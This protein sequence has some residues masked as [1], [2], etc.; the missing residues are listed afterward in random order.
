MSTTQH[1]SRDVPKSEILEKFEEPKRNTSQATGDKRRHTDAD[2]I[3]NYHGIPQFNRSNYTYANVFPNMM[4]HAYE[5]GPNMNGGG[6]DCYIRGNPGSGKSTFLNWLAARL[7]EINDEQVVWRGSSSRSEW[8]P[9]AP[10]TRLCVPEGADIKARLE[11]RDPRESS[12]D[13][14]RDDLEE[15]AREVVTYRTPTDLNK[16]VLDNGAFHVVYPD[17]RMRGCNEALEESA[18]RTIET[19]PNRDTAFS[20]DDPA[21]HWWFAWALARVERGPY[22]FCTWIADEIGDLVPADAR[23]DAF[24]SYQKVDLLKD[25]WADMRK[26]GLTVLAAGHSEKDVHPKIL[27]KLRWRIQMPG[28]ANPTSKSDLTGFDNIPMQYDLTSQMDIGECLCYTESNFERL[29]WKDVGTETSHKL[30]IE[31]N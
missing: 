16:R 21:N 25:T 13:L 2:S 26:M 9:L 22:H 15:I 27:R 20:E 17:P 14:D 18:E 29:R 28:Q 30:K 7:L 31:I 5:A 3:R 1:D 10:W 6:T 4:V 23:K 24:G 12:I 11:A 8:L 19:P